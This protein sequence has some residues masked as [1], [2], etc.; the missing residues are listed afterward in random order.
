M[1]L[2]CL[3]VAEISY[4]PLIWLFYMCSHVLFVWEKDDGDIWKIIFIMQTISC[5][6][7][8]YHVVFE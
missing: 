1:I 3:I 4:L 7:K 2:E 8:F 5:P 6:H